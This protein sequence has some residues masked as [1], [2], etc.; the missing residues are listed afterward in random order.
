LDAPTA[1][2][3]DLKAGGGANNPASKHLGK[4]ILKLAAH[5]PPIRRN[6]PNHGHLQVL[7]IC[8]CYVRNFGD[9]KSD[10]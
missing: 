8:R 9:G 6:C 7:A 10:S 3:I 2:T 1:V 5:L 4:E